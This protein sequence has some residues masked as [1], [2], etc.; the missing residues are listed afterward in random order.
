VTGAQGTGPRPRATARRTLP[1]DLVPL[2]D[3]PGFDPRSHA[4]GRCADDLRPLSALAL[5][6]DA[7]R[8]RF[9]SPPTW[10]PESWPEYRFARREV[11]SAAVLV[12][13]V[14]HEEPT[15]L[16]TERTSHLPVH[17]GQ[18]AFPGGKKDLG[19]ADLMAT[20]LREAAEEIGLSPQE[21]EIAA[22]LPPFTTGTGYRITPIVGLLRPG[23]PVH[24][25]AAEV[26]H[27]FELPLAQVLDPRTHYRHEMEAQGTLREWIS[28]ACTVGGEERL[29]WGATAAVLR[30]LYLFFRA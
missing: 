1:P 18:I 15:V 9:R 19:D 7:I 30:D 6:P 12:P 10:Q 24:A 22:D 21:V 11:V 5:G 4:V 27:I 16:L 17:S 8:S 20:A 13:L 23:T 25:S 28:I 26:A 2:A 3:L 29:V 14:L